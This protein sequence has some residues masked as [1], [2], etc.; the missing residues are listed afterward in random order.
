MVQASQAAEALLGIGG[1]DL[2]AVGQL[3]LA[4]FPAATTLTD[5]LANFSKAAP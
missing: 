3:V 1:A 5:V 2:E 4:G